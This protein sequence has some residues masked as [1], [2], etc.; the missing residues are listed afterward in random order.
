MPRRKPSWKEGKGQRPKFREI[1]TLS[2]SHAGQSISSSERGQ[3]GQTAVPREFVEF[4]T[5]SGSG[6][7]PYWFSLSFRQIT[8]PASEVVR[9]MPTDYL[10]HLSNRTVA[11]CAEHTSFWKRQNR[12]TVS[13]VRWG[14][15]ALQFANG[16][17]RIIRS[18]CG[19]K[20]TL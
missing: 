16:L 3:S 19:L 9:G 8:P 15:G 13:R 5:K 11:A 6:T 14:V 20:V 1:G 10:P 2:R 12:S 4:F 7:M 17:T 18:L